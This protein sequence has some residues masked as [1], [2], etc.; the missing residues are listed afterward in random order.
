VLTSAKD[1]HQLQTVLATTMTE[2]ERE[3]ARLFESRERIRPIW[4]RA[5]APEP[6]IARLELAAQRPPS[7]GIYAVLRRWMAAIA[8]SRARVAFAR[9]SGLYR[10][11]PRPQR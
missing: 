4:L 7:C 9:G 2:V 8:L 3:L 1:H 5:T 11:C 6:D 10:P